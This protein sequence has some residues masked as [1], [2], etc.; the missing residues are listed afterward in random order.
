[1][2][3]GFDVEKATKLSTIGLGLSLGLAWS[4]GV[5]IVGVM[6]LLM[7]QATVEPFKNL[8]NIMY[9]GWGDTAGKTLLMTVWS[10]S[11]GFVGGFLIGLFYNLFAKRFN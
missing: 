11:H 7:D 2:V 1:M 9:P 8:F 5:L 3:L 4:I 10:F 6:A